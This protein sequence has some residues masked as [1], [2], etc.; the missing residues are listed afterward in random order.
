MQSITV[1]TPS[2]AELIPLTFLRAELYIVEPEDD[3]LL[4][5]KLAEAKTL[6]EN[7]TQRFFLTTEFEL[8]LD[9]FPDCRE[10]TIPRPP[11]LSVESIE[12][13]DINGALQTF[14]D[15]NYFVDTRSH[16]GRVRLKSG[17]SWPTT[18]TDRPSAVIITCTAGYGS[19]WESVP[20]DI[21]NAVKLLVADAWENRQETY[22][23]QGVGIKEMPRGAYFKLWAYKSLRDF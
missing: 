11:L 14:D 4:L 23:I 20:A 7:F 15:S 2:T 17:K 18:E 13:Y 3:A 5:S 9:E 8:A 12:Y 1:T 21:R 22:V 19:T 6:A 10:I 16:F